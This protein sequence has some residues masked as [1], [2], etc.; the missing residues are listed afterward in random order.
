MASTYTPAGII[1]QLCLKSQTL[2]LEKAVQS[3]RALLSLHKT[4]PLIK[5]L[6]KFC[7][8]KDK[9]LL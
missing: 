6:H 1:L 8:V 7:W 4:D 5:S 9:T 3:K 2:V